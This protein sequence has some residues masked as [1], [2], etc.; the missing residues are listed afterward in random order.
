MQCLFN[1]ISF[2]L[3]RTPRQADSVRSPSNWWDWWDWWA[4]DSVYHSLFTRTSPFD[5]QSVYAWLGCLGSVTINFAYVAGWPYVKR[6]ISVVMW[7][8]KRRDSRCSYPWRCY[9]NIKYQEVHSDKPCGKFFNRK[10][11]FTT[12]G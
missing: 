6:Y 2:R 9:E 4:P 10:L 1:E 7:Q 8:P 12:R 5:W 11:I 3:V